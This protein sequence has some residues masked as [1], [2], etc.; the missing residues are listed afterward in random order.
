MS[1]SVVWPGAGEAIFAQQAQKR[2]VEGDD[3]RFRADFCPFVLGL[4]HVLDGIEDQAV[5]PD[6]EGGEHH[7]Q[8]VAGVERQG[9]VDHLAGADG[10]QG[11]GFVGVL[12]EGACGGVEHV[13]GHGLWHGFAEGGGQCWGPGMR[14]GGEWRL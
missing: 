6:D 12:A 3:P 7:L 10:G 9:G 8:P 1:P 4:M 5:V 11:L 2:A 13:L 14:L